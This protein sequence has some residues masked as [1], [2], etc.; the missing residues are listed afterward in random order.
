VSVFAGVHALHQSEPLKTV[1]FHF[2]Q[3]K[4]AWLLFTETRAAIRKSLLSQ[5]IT[6]L[7]Q[8]LFLLK[9]IGRE[10]PIMKK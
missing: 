2:S 5:R 8:M 9:G 3:E 10:G 7:R 4:D 1:Q 6:F